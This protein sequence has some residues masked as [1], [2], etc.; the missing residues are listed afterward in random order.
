MISQ[1]GVPPPR[2]LPPPPN[3]PPK[4]PMRISSAATIAKKLDTV[5]IATSRFP[6]WDS[7]WAST[8]STSGLLSRYQSPSVTATTEFFGLRPVAN[9]FGTSVGTT[10]IRGFGRS[11]IAQRRSTMS[12]SSG[13]SSRSTT[14]A[15]DA[16]S[17][18]L[19]D[20]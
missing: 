16:A 15:R 17:A 2:S 10:A 11:A 6:M 14:F 8:P 5:M 4:R 9:A 13:A 12:W 7:S 1:T 19:S 18:I 3:I 20:V